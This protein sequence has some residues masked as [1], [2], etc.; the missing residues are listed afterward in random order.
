M[1]CKSMS[2]KSG[3]AAVLAAITGNQPAGD[4]IAGTDHMAAIEKAVTQSFGEGETAGLAAGTAAERTRVKAIMSS[5]H[6]KGREGLAQHFAFDTAM[7]PEAAGA[8]LAAAP[9][10]AAVE[11]PR[12]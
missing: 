7:T 10:A 4:T 8:A 5:E 6:A 11:A 2:Q 12:G 9:K 3:L 1:E